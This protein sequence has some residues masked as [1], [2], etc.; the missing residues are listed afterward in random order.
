MSRE[1]HLLTFTVRVSE[2]LS[3]LAGGDVDRGETPVQVANTFRENASKHVS[4]E[5][6]MLGTGMISG[7]E[8]VTLT[9]VENHLWR[10]GMLLE[11]ANS[12][13]DWIERGEVKLEPTRCECGAE[14]IRH[15][16][17]LGCCTP[18]SLARYKRAESEA[19]E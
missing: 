13:A 10:M 15:P 17:Q 3:L 11:N 16:G 4:Y 8:E 2:L 6:Q 14:L 9:M 7:S 18:C 5:L 19:A 1:D 12:V